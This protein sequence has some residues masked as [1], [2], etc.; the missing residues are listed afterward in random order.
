MTSMFDGR[1]SPRPRAS[2]VQIACIFFALPWY[3]I[4]GGDIRDAEYGALLRTENGVAVWWTSSGWKVGRNKAA[5]AATNAAVHIR[6]ARNEAEAAQLVLRSERP[7]RGVR[8]VPGGLKGPGEIPA[9]AV[10]VL[11][12]RYLDIAQ[13]TDASA[14]PG[15]WPDPLMPI[16]GPLDLDAGVN[17]PFWIRVSIP[18]GASAGAYTGSLAIRHEGGACEVPLTVEVYGF[19]LPDRMTC[20]TAFGFNPGRVFQYHRVETNAGKRELLEKY[21]STFSAHHIS[22]YDPAPLDLIRVTWPD[23]KPPPG[24]FADWEGVKTVDNEVK[25]GVGALLLL[26]ENPTANV[27]AGFKPPIPIPEKGLRLRFDIRTA[28]P[29]HMALVALGHRDEAGNWMSGH[30]RDFLI[31]GTGRWQSFDT[32]IDKFPEGARSVQLRLFAT[33]WADDGAPTGLVWFDNV[34]LQ[35]AG[36]GKEFV[37]AGD[38]EPPAPRTEPV[39]P[40]SQLQ[41]RLDFSA[42]DRAMTSAIDGHRFNS[43][44]LDIPGLGGGTYFES[45]PPS[46]RG[47]TEDTPEYRALLASYCGQIEAHLKDKGWLDEAFVYWFDEPDPHQYEFVKNGFAKLRQYCPSIPRMLTEQVEPGLIGGPN[48]WCPLTTSYEHGA[49]ELR[50]AEGEKFWW[51]VCCAPKAPYTTLFIDHPATEL[52]A[53]LWQTWQRNIDGILV[54]DTVYWTSRTAYPEG[55]QNP[56]EDPMSWVSGYDSK[57]GQKRPWGNGDGRFLYPPAAVFSSSE[58]PVLDPPIESIRWEMLRDGI[59][60]YEYLAI[61]RRLIE[62]KKASL[63]AER[64]AEL[65]RLLEV[66]AEVTSSLK[67]FAK[68]PAPIEK[69]RDEVAQAIE[70]LGR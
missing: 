63:P 67:D 59:E 70:G 69:R 65:H 49:A 51:Y 22:P 37:T 58:G 27:S 44:R 39:V 56:Y 14:R 8:I 3:A 9:G 35:D 64:I 57:P 6:A 16:A 43:F 15:P 28:I 42:W 68:D 32:V 20:A 18:R 17:H 40:L 53:W 47:F 10:E 2:V 7:L 38:F 11:Q 66:P 1:P 4:A 45:E 21:W 50:R 13:P 19:E 62:Q 34:S 55:M 5:P 26:D 36:T 23:V 31:E 61:L 24:R 25:D 48:L 41:V 46:L 33:R 60:D 29:G 52:R 30:N 54:W 12:V